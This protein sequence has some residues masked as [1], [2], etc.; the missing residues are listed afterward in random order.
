[1]RNLAVTCWIDTHTS[2]I[3]YIG[4]YAQEKLAVKVD[5]GILTKNN[6]VY[7]RYCKTKLSQ[8]RKKF[9]V[10][11]RVKEIGLACRPLACYPQPKT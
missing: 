1:M 10:C 3:K 11:K 9:A 8:M 6:K 4:H 2:T 7:N 5:D